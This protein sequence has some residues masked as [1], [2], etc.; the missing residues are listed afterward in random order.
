MNNRQIRNEIKQYQRELA[1][2]AAKLKAADLR[3]Y[4]LVRESY[5]LEARIKEL[6]ARIVSNRAAESFLFSA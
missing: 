2:V 4:G 3:D 6:K 5:V 1:E